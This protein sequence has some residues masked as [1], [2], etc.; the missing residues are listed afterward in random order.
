[1]NYECRKKVEIRRGE[2]ISHQF[3]NWERDNERK[4]Y[5]I[6]PKRDEKIGAG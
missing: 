5:K 1:M 6:K 3:I 4:I 2:E